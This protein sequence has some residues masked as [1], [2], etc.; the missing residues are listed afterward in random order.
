MAG[1]LETS[2]G[3]GGAVAVACD[4][5]FFNPDGSLMGSSACFDWTPMAK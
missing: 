5:Y 4:I 2:D 3:G 1:Q